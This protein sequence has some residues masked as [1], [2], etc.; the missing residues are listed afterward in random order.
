MSTAVIQFFSHRDGWEFLEINPNPKAAP[1]TFVILQPPI[2]SLHRRELRLKTQ[3]Q[4]GR[5]RQVWHGNWVAVRGP[6]I[7]ALGLE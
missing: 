6:N 5:Q 3:G 2:C 4:K 1:M 7:L